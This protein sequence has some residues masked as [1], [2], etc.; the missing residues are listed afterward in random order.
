MINSAICNILNGEKSEINIQE[1]FDEI[2]SGLCEPIL[3]GVFLALYNTLEEKYE[4]IVA[5]INSARNALKKTN[6]DT[7]YNFLIENICIDQKKQ[8]LDISFATDIICASN[9]VAVVKSQPYNCFYKNNS[10]ETL[11]AFGIDINNLEKNDFEKTKFQYS[12]INQESAYLKYTQELFRILP[13]ETILNKINPFLNPFNT[14]NCAIALCDKNKVE[15]YAK[16]CLSLNYTNSIVFSSG[17][18][19]YVSIEEETI[20]SEAWKN[21]IFS[22][23]ITPE[24]LGIQK[25]SLDSIKTENPAHCAEIIQAVFEN[26]LKDSNY[27]AIIM[28]SALSLYITKCANSLMQGFE[29]AKKTIESNMAIEK[30]NQLKNTF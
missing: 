15:E 19:P 23:T 18:F 14:K 10:F 27:S 28:N 2:F 12:Y 1:C 26:K 25:N 29:L 11:K 13:F 30:L 7:D 22:Y 5:G 16:I 3:S 20:V 17:D 21:K 24:L 9:D 8:Y 4:D 6:L